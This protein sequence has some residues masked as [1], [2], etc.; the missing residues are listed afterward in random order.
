M[1]DGQH[2]VLEVKDSNNSDDDKKAKLDAY[3]KSVYDYSA[4]HV[5]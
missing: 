4:K 3:G 5:K 2:V 1:T